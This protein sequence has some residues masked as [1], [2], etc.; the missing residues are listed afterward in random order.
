MSEGR[1]P[2]VDFLQA[3][4]PVDVHRSFKLW[5]SFTPVSKNALVSTSVNLLV[6]LYEFEFYE[7]FNKSTTIFHGQHS[8]R[9]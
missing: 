4:L 6:F 3:S 5:P 9:P 1:Q 7:T 8:Y 2:E